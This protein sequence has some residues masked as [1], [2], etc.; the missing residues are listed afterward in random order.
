MQVLDPQRTYDPATVHRMAFTDAASRAKK[1]QEASAA[2][3]QA[4][5]FVDA[6]K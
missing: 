3:K 1:H 5:L 2:L 6:H 4:L